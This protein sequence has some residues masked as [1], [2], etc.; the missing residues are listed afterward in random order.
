MEEKV[1]PPHP[2]TN[3]RPYIFARKHNETKY[4]VSFFV[5]EDLKRVLF[6]GKKYIIF[7]YQINEQ[8]KIYC[9]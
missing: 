8:S 7:L 1:G 6:I 4:E 5:V 3:L 2:V 9:L